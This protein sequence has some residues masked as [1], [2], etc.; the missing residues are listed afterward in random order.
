M[1]LGMGI[2]S[3]RVTFRPKPQQCCHATLAWTPVRYRSA[4][5]CAVV[6]REYRVVACRL[7][8]ALD[9]PD[10]DMR[11]RGSFSFYSHQLIC[12]RGLTHDAPA[13]TQTASENLVQ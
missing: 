3:H 12:R 6:S 2:R 5:H 4:S 13:M 1:I 8:H 11:C 10:E 7:Q 9:L